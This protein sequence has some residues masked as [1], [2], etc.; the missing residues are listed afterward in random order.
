MGWTGQHATHYKRGTVDRKA[1]CD[2]YFMEGLN[3]G[4]YNV[5]K[6]ALVGSVYYAAV[7]NVKRYGE[8]QP[9]Y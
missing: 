7:Q 6:S 3:A 2:A 4:F 9:D 1:E 8:E 5:L